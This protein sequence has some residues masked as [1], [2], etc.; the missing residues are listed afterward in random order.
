MKK[1]KADLLVINAGQLVTVAGHSEKPKRGFELAEPGV[2]SGG[3]VASRDGQIV[4][5]G[6]TAAVMK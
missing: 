1:M 4:A 5:V 6:T 2:I 3:A